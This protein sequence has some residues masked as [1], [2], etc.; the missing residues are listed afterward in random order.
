MY[1]VGWSTDGGASPAPPTS[2]STVPLVKSITKVLLH[3]LRCSCKHYKEGPRSK[4]FTTTQIVEQ[5][6]QMFQLSAGEKDM[7]LLGVYNTI[8]DNSTMLSTWKK[9]P[10]GKAE[11]QHQRSHY[12]VGNKTVC[13][14]TFKFVYE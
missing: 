9:G 12:M 13:R 8:T 2:R 6:Q 11:R 4:Q 1:S 10:K 7:L 14:D 5:R 3:N